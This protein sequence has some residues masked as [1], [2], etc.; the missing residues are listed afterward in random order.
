MRKNEHFLNVYFL[1]GQHQNQAEE[2]EF[3][4]VLAIGRALFGSVILLPSA[5]LVRVN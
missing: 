5:H 4:G 1:Y 2:P 3:A